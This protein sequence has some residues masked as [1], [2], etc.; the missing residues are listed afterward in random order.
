MDRAKRRKVTKLGF[1]M[2]I[3]VIGAMGYLMWN[4]HDAGMLPEQYELAALCMMISLLLIEGIFFIKSRMHREK[5]KRIGAGVVAVLLGLCLFS[6]SVYASLMLD[7]T[8]D[9][10]RAFAGKDGKSTENFD[11]PFIMYLSGSDTRS[12]TLKKSRSDV[13]ILMVMNPTTNRILLLNTPRDYYIPNA[14]GGG[15]NDKL[16][17]CGLYGIENSMKSLGNFY[18]VPVSHYG[19]INFTGFERLIDALGGITVDAPSDFTTYKSN[20]HFTKGINQCNGKMALAY[21]RE[22]H[23]FATGDN[24]RGEHQMEVITAMVKKASDNKLSLIANY[25]NILN[26]LEGTFVTDYSDG[27]LSA[28]IKTFLN[29]A[30]KWKIERYAVTGTGGK[31][32]SYSAPN[33]YAYVTYPDTASVEKAKGMLKQF[34]TVKE[35]NE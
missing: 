34:M 35:E 27:D 2:Y 14:A 22:R 23:A 11:K 26:S 10:L 29:G 15:A 20:I 28:L 7:K 19:Q 16:T 9:V 13:N 21:A 30:G 33:A 4:I 32:T 1:L 18:G 24:A 12:K 3:G 31:A 5:G 8:Q 6:G 17:H 25:G